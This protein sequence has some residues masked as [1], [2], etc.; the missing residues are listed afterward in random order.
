M[1][2]S[3]W[4]ALASLAILVGWA[5]ERG[6][7]LS[8]PKC[9]SY[10]LCGAFVDARGLTGILGCDTIGLLGEMS[11]ERLLT[12]EEAARRL[13]VSP[14]GVKNWLRQGKLRG[15]KVGRLWRITESDLRAF[16][17]QARP[18]GPLRSAD[19]NWLDSDLSDLGQFEPYEWGSQGP[20]REASVTYDAGKGFMVE[21]GR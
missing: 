4:V 1:H 17:D 5:L 13:S 2:R 6:L 18:I 21:D 3:T 11:M 12:P 10:P 16:V 20:P 9:D 14:K 19:A 7:D 15:L 8:H